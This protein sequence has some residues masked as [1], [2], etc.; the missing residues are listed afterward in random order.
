[1]FWVTNLI[2]RRVKFQK[3]RRLNQRNRVALEDFVD[4]FL[5]KAKRTEEKEGLI[6][7]TFGPT[8]E[9]NAPEGFVRNRWLADTVRTR[10]ELLEN[11]V[12]SGKWTCPKWKRFEKKFNIS[13]TV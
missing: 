1:M 11:F 4:D 2:M 9:E 8:S 7:Q 6:S 13:V 3:Y 5:K 12:A 10:I